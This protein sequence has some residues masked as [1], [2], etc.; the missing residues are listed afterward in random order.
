M[1]GKRLL[2]LGL[3]VVFILL[4]VSVLFSAIWGSPALTFSLLGFSFVFGVILY[5]LMRFHKKEVEYR[6]EMEKKEN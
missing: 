2:F 1:N 4:N 5:F 3:T 6:K